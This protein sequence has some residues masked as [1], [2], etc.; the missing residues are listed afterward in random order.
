MNLSGIIDS[1]FEKPKLVE[2]QPEF[3]DIIK[4]EAKKDLPKVSK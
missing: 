1:A 3:E 2:F 4:L